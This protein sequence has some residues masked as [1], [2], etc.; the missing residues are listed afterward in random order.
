LF[1]LGKVSLASELDKLWT[2]LWTRGRLDIA[3]T[4]VPSVRLLSAF[5]FLRDFTSGSAEFLGIFYL[6]N[7]AYV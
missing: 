5:S 4:K 2:D 7:F 3:G 6:F 1:D